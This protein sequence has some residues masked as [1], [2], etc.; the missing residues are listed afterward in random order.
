M[1]TVVAFVPARCGSTAIP[2]KNIKLLAGKP[3]IYWNLE[4]IEQCE[5]IDKVIVATD[6][7]KIQKVVEGFNFNKC[8]IYRRSVASATNSASTELVM[9]EYIEQSTLSPDDTF[10][11]VQATSPLTQSA[12][13][14]SA[15]HQLHDDRA[16]SLLTVVPFKRFIWGDDGRA[17]NYDY[18]KRPRRQEMPNRYLENGAF[19]ISTVKS[20]VHTKNRLSGKISL[21]VMPEYTQVELDEPDDW[22]VAEAL[23]NRFRVR[24]SAKASQVKLVVSD[25]DGVLTDSR[26]I[27]TEK[28]DELKSFN[29]RDGMAFELFRKMGIATGIVTSEKTKLVEARAKKMKIDYLFQGKRDGGKLEAI[30]EIC[31]QVGCTLSEVAYIGDDINCFD[32]L[33][34]VGFPACPND[35]DPLIL[36]LP[37]IQVLDK[38]GGNGVVREFYNQ[39]FMPRN[40]DKS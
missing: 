19:Y 37:G 32:A 13:F 26:M 27:Y 38:A 2:E 36:A 4:A 25:V 23:A 30:L 1:S 29:T 24:Q 10:I 20:I 33:N 34:S 7:D 14:T 18:G 21:F 31:G 11:L 9:L 22:I 3:L 35:A 16:D 15:L 17:I 12:D 5:D 6:C 40:T 28:G 8:S 39:Y